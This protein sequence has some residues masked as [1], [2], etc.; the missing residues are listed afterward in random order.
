MRALP[1]SIEQEIDFRIQLLETKLFNLSPI[2]ILDSI[3]IGRYEIYALSKTY[4]DI[5]ENLVLMR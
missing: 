2:I 1:Q 3:E 5:R 4:H